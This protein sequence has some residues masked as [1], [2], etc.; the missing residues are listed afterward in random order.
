MP[1]ET[2][3]SD[4]IQFFNEHLN[5][6]SVQ[7]D[8]LPLSIKSRISA[9]DPWGRKKR[10]EIEAV[11]LSPDEQPPNVSYVSVEFGNDRT[12]SMKVALQKKLTQFLQSKKTEIASEGRFS[13]VNDSVRGSKAYVEFASHAMRGKAVRVFWPEM[14]PPPD[15]AA[16]IA[17]ERLQY[18][19]RSETVL[20]VE[21]EESLLSLLQFLLES[22]GYSVLTAVDGAEALELYR[23]EQTKIDLVVS[24]MGLPKLGGWELFLEMKKLNPG[25]KSILASG[26]LDGSLRE[27]MLRSGAKDFIQKPYV[28]NAILRRIREVLDEPN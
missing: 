2:D 6:S 22:N 8:E 26:F 15:R 25:V 16:E 7:V 24:D 3:H 1:T 17:S 21:D 14:D 27:Q 12:E 4:F 20:L 23:R 18:Q 28:P 10:Q 19:G 5:A 11:P 13:F 9:F